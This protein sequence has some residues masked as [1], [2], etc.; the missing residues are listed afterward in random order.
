MKYLLL[1]LS[2]LT[3]GC[4]VQS[5][6]PSEDVVED[7]VVEPTFSTCPFEEVDCEY[8]GNCG[9]YVDGDSDDLCDHSQ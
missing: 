5:I 8:P 2:V 4:S 9:R 7:I 1:M 6:E 3:A